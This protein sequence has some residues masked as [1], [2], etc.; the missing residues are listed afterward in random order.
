MS[1]FAE[2]GGD[3][4]D[5][6]VLLHGL[7]ATG[8]VWAPLLEF[9]GT[10]WHGRWFAADL[11]GHGD[12]AR[13]ARYSVED[14]AATVGDA[15]RNRIE[16]HG[17]LLILGHSFGGAIGLACASG[18][19]GFQPDAVFGVGIKLAWTDQDVSRM[20]AIAAQPA[21]R[22]ATEEEAWAR[23]LKV[24][25]LA[26]LVPSGSR[27]AARG[28]VA[29]GQSWR[30]AM[31]PAANKTG[32]P[33]FGEITAAARCPFHLARGGLDPLVTLEQTRAFDPAATDLD[34]YGHNIMVEAPEPLWA[35]LEARCARQ[36]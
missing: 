20:Q 22:F 29:D 15:L 16:P 27:V 9:I 21:K 10:R 2:E 30:L 8:G 18:R 19:Y 6:L 32:A 5:L 4:G 34:S 3:G 11:P 1:L 23:Y 26:G 35:W 12:S 24:S 33:A 31:D 7:G 14:A 28:I 17:R 36:R 25:G 13:A